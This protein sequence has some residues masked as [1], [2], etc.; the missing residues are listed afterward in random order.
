MEE[1]GS[2]VPV[3]YN[4]AIVW[5]IYLGWIIMV[6]VGVVKF[7]IDLGYFSARLGIIARNMVGCCASRWGG[8]VGYQM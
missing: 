7:G 5:I 3:L 6:L 8:S 4:F 1:G 2:T